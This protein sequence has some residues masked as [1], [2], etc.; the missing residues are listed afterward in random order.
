MFLLI[1]NKGGFSLVLEESMMDINQKQTIHIVT[2]A[3][4]LY[5][6]HLAVMLHSL[7][8]NKSS[9]NPIRIYVIDSNISNMNKVLLSRTVGKFNANIQFLIIDRA[10]YEDFKTYKYVTQETYYRISIPNLLDQSIQKVIYLDSDIIIKKDITEFWNLDIDQYFLAAVEDCHV[11]DAR[12]SDLLMPKDSKYFN[13][14]VLLINLLKWREEGITDKIIEFIKTNSSRIKY[15]DQDALNAILYD[16]WLQLDPTW[17]YTTHHLEEF[18]RLKIEPGI[19]HY[20]GKNKPWQSDHPL[21]D[22]Y[23]NYR[24][25]AL[26]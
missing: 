2:A 16:K 20:V 21:K 14:G 23:Y 10:I 17:N 5:A 7:F 4:D 13:A 3:N 9:T 11:R 6:E 26:S 22:E 15:C 1:M 24:K 8:V 12:N 25:N 18:P 19:I